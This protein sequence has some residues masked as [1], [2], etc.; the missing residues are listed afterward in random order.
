MT[1]PE[2]LLARAA[3]VL[4]DD[5]GAS[6]SEVSAALGISRATLHRQFP[7]RAELVEAIV[8]HTVN[9]VDTVLDGLS[10]TDDPRLLDRLVEQLLP[11]AQRYGFLALHP[12]VVADER[13]QRIERRLLELFESQQR[14]GALRADVVAEWHLEV[15][16][17]LL[18][19]AVRLGNDGLLASRSIPD[20]VRTTFLQGLGGGR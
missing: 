5:H 4:T 8:G 10:R 15:L 18:L 19:S 14:S 17:A 1:L 20:L 11:L 13:V 16:V 2:A 9:E 3:E 6:L 7:G 12:E